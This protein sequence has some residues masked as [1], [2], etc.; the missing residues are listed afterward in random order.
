VYVRSE[1]TKKGS[2]AKPNLAPVVVSE[3]LG[4]KTTILPPKATHDRGL[5]TVTPYY[6]VHWI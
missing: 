3:A 1:G 2:H 6:S 5:F 4:E